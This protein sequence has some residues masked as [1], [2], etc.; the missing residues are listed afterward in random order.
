M[1]ATANKAFQRTSNTPGLSANAFGIFFAES[2]SVCG[3]VELG[4][5]PMRR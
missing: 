5:K 4:V 2:H 1:R 3:A